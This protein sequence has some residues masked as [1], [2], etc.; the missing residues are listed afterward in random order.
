MF[1]P[2]GMNDSLIALYGELLEDRKLSATE[3]QPLPVASETAC[4][5]YG[6]GT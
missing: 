5:R 1:T 4:D 3:L 6:E 2:G